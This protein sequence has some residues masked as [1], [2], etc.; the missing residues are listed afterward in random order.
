M[1]AAAK[2]SACLI[3]VRGGSKGIP[4]KN[5]AEIVPG[6]SLL[7]WT[8]RQAV[9]VFPARDVFVSS[10]DPAMLAVAAR[11]GVVAVERPAALARDESTTASV[12]DHLLATVGGDRFGSLAVLQ[13]TSPL[14]QAGDIA[15]ARR[16]IATGDFDSVVGVFEETR[17]H[18]AKMYLVEAGSAVPV[19]PAY[20]ASRRQDLPRVF[21]RN[22]AIFFVTKA[23][24]QSTGRLWGGRTGLVEMPIARSIDIDAPD[25]L[26]AARRYLASAGIREA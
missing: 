15:E 21:R 23:H 11:T 18:P 24:Y 19:L 20:E 16:L 8:I 5:L 1:T 14:R 9:E 26:D 22:G 3:P 7:E 6:V 25:D 2:D 12:M 13:V 10:D 4:G 17:C